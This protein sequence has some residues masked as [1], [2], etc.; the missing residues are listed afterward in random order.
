MSGHNVAS[1]IKK[2][3]SSLSLGQM[4]LFRYFRI[5]SKKYISEK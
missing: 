1:E 2:D 3:L 4:K 5:V